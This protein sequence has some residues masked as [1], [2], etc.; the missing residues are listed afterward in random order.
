MD[1]DKQFKDDLEKATALS[2][3]TLALDQFRR[4]KLQYSSISDVSSTTN[5]LKSTCKFLADF[6][7]CLKYIILCYTIKFIAHN[8]LSSAASS[9]STT[10]PRP[11]SFGNSSTSYG[12]SSLTNSSSSGSIAP[13]PI[14]PARNIRGNSNEPDLISFTNPAGSDAAS[15]LLSTDP[16]IGLQ[17]NNRLDSPTSDSHA[18]F[19]QMV[20][21]MHR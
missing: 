4:N 8:T 11:G 10:R 6:H 12:T 15:S 5:I 1:Y 13:P 9:R 17:T 18:N 14:V 2:L 7:F 19:L 20:D 16:V 21:E 3:E